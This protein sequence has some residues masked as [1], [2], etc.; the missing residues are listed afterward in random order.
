MM[1]DYDIAEPLTMVQ[2]EARYRFLCVA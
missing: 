2:A 1:S